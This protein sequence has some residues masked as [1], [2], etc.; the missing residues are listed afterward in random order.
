MKNTAFKT[1]LDTSEQSKKRIIKS[2]TPVN[3]KQINW[4]MI[5]QSACKK[6]FKI[7]CLYLL[8]ILTIV[9]IAGSLGI[10][11]FLSNVST[12][13]KNHKII[14]YPCSDS[15][16]FDNFDIFEEY[17]HYLDS[18]KVQTVNQYFTYFPF[19]ER[20]IT[21]NRLLSCYCESLNGNET[22]VPSDFSRRCQFSKNFRKFGSVGNII[23]LPI[24][25]ITIFIQLIIISKITSYFPFEYK[26]TLKVNQII[27]F[28]FVLSINLW[29]NL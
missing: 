5:E 18:M 1:K 13:L 17:N 7:V 10:F 15:E 11:I 12:N 21:F 6:W 26:T 27:I 9:V 29:V 4:G 25:I 2:T 3:P 24:Y 8:L 14:Y 22:T 19:Y 16:D 20:Y 28:I 23:A